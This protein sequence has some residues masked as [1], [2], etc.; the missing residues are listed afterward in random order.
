MTRIELFRADFELEV[1]RT[2]RMLERI[3]NDKY[4]WQPHAKSMNIKKLA[5]HIAEL[6]GWLSTVF[7]QDVLDFSKTP[8]EENENTITTDLLKYYEESVNQGRALLANATEEQLD[9]MWTMRD[10]EV[11]Y[12]NCPRHV[13]LRETFNQTVHHR[14]QLGVFLRLLDVKIPGTYGP[15]ADEMEG[16]E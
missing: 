3:P 12:M 11:V 2:R 14:A 6:P 15:S 5:N 4:D 13:I 1:P 9:E 8:Y 7:E 10:G 16:M